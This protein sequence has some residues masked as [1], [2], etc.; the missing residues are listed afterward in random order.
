MAIKLAY[1]FVFWGL[2]IFVLSVTEARSLST[3][4][5]G[6]QVLSTSSCHDVNVTLMS[7]SCDFNHGYC[8][9]SHPRY[10]Q[11]EWKQYTTISAIGVDSLHDGGPF[12]YPYNLGKHTGTTS[13]VTT[14]TISGGAVCIQLWYAMAHPGSNLEV[15]LDVNGNETSLWKLSG[16]HANHCE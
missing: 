5:S 12:L 16:N 4:V 11:M 9:F 13:S 2:S 10:P 1:M 6:V 14:A 15:L 8:S 7:Q 3:P